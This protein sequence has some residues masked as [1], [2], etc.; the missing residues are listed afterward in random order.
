MQLETQALRGVGGG[1]GLV[2]SYGCSSHRDADPFSSLGTLSSF[3]IGSPVFHPID[4]CVHLLLYL[5][6]TVIASQEIAISAKP[7][8]HM[9]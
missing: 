3:F 8:W 5:P 6:G 2:S 1:E 4:D 7:S 9:Q